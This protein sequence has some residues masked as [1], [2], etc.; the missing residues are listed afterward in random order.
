MSFRVYVPDEPGPCPLALSQGGDCAGDCTWCDEWWSVEDCW[1]VKETKSTKETKT[2]EAKRM[3]ECQKCGKEAKLI[4]AGDP[5]S[6]YYCGP[7][8]I[9]FWERET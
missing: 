6:S 8:N 9:F 4:E 7:C 2:P 5:W 1:Q 3:A